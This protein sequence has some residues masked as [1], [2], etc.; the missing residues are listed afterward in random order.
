MN[1]LI[2]LR[3]TT[4]VFLIAL[5]SFA[6]SPLARAACG[7]PDG[8]C[9]G[10][11]TAE[12]DGALSHLQTGIQNTANGFEALSMNT[13]G[14]FNTAVG[15]GALHQNVSAEFNTATGFQALLKNTGGF[16]NTA[17]G[18]GA[19]H[20]NIGGFAN[21]ATGL[22]AL[23]ENQTG[24]H[25][26]ATG[27]SA[28][29]RNTDGSENTAN[30]AGALFLNT[31]DNNTANGVNALFSN[32]IGS[33]NTAIGF[34]ALKNNKDFDGDPG[35]FNTAVGVEALKSNLRGDSNTAVG[36]KALHDSISDDNT[37]IGAGALSALNNIDGNNTAC[38]VG[39]L[40]Q[41]E[42]GENNT[43]IGHSALTGLPPRRP[44]EEVAFS[45]NTAVGVSALQNNSGGSNTAVG[46]EALLNNTTG[47]D[48]IALGAGAGGP[49]MTGSQNIYIGSTAKAAN[50]NFKIRI[51]S[52]TNATF[53]NTF[54]IGISGTPVVGDTVVVNTDG[55]LGTE[56]SAAR[57][58]KEIRPMDKT[59]EAILALKPVSFLYKSD[60]KATQRFGLIAEDVAKVNPDL[61][62]RDR[63]GEIYSVRYEA[64]NA[65]LLIQFLK[66]H[67][68]V[69]E[70]EGIVTGLA[71]TVK[72][73]AAQIQKVSAQLEVNKTA[74]QIVLNNQ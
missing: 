7:K 47:D 66:E 18:A 44:G 45:D 55:Q 58:K 40:S 14:N 1:P 69:D 50:E 8:G 12:G 13:I 31:A 53:V 68:K 10:R 32:T 22:N 15:A 9:D 72:E 35:E 51:G 2:Q 67:R 27:D 63:K 34:E 42:H 48:N 36:I 28:L 61:V 54:I 65:M 56:M 19:L 16:F 11:N 52:T 74:P 49:L 30:G 20:E 64:V 73:Q 59:S 37:A 4:P 6:L 21:T 62:V 38:G 70:L 5:A 57:F 25:N 23:R 24:N 26:T 71:A 43:A 60:S 41:L 39:A 29:G 46:K 33:D 3:K 17:T